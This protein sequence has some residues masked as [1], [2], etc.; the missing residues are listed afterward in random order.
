MAS[1][2][3]N[4]RDTPKLQVAIEDFYAPGKFITLTSDQSGGPI[5]LT[6]GDVAVVVDRATFLK[7]VSI[8]GG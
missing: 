5:I 3:P 6:I 1:E 4:Q 8:Y 2:L 7:G